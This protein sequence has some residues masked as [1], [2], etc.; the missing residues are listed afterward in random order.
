M[1]YGRV[2]LEYALEQL[3]L[4][5]EDQRVPAHPKRPEV[6]V[7]RASRLHEGN[8][9][10]LPLESGQKA[11]IRRAGWEFR[12]DVALLWAADTTRAL[13]RRQAKYADRGSCSAPGMLTAHTP[14]C[15][16][17]SAPRVPLITQM[18]TSGGSR[19]TDEKAV[20]VIPW[21]SASPWVV[22]TVTPVAKAPRARRKSSPLN[23]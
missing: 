11:G 10:A 7:T 14:F 5:D 19:E 4:R 3:R 8:E 15:S 21:A 2:G 6:A 22:I 12:G 13:A 20:A 16:I 1:Q 9:L 17:V 23:S 18:S